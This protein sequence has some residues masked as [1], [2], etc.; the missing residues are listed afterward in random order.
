MAPSDLSRAELEFLERVASEFAVAVDAYLAKQQLML[1][2]DRVRVLFDITNALVSKLS[3]DELFP[4][5]SKQLSGVIRHDI[6]LLT[7][8]NEATGRLDLY[9]LHF[10]GALMFEPEEKSIDPEGTPF[11]EAMASG[12]PVVVRD[13]DVG[14]YPALEQRRVTGLKSGCFIPLIAPDRTLG[15]LAVARTTE[16]PWTEDEIELLAQVARQIAMA[17]ENSLAYRELAEM[18]ERLA[19]EKLYLE[20]EIR[21]DQ[22]IGN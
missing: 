1:E 20:D 9:S 5:I 13:L 14:R 3:P 2:R 16:D 4:A 22:N 17:I 18:K 15:T 8:C 7:L 11:A 6:A 10:T 12:K 21:L 19:T